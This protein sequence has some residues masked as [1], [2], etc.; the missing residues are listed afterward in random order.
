MVVEVVLDDRL[1]IKQGE[2]VATDLLQCFGVRETDLV[3][4]AYADLL[5]PQA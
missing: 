5:A 4:T 1:D 2:Q 3:A